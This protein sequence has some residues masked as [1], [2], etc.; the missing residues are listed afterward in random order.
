MSDTCCSVALAVGKDAQVAQ[1]YE[2]GVVQTA[3]ARNAAA[4]AAESE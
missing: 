2:L 1:A 4:A 3:A